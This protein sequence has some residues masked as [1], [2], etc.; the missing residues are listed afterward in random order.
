VNAADAGLISG[1][2]KQRTELSNSYTNEN[3]CNGHFDCDEDADN[4]AFQIL[5]ENYG[6]GDYTPGEFIYSCE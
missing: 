4:H 3:Q 6:G 2:F 1:E 5:K